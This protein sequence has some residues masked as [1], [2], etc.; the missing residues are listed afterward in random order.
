MGVTFQVCA[1]ASLAVV[2][3][4]WSILLL[5]AGVELGS[6]AAQGPYQ[7]LLPDLV[8]RRAGGERRPG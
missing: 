8:A 4:Y 2:P 1:V 7:G 5:M 6:N 3:G